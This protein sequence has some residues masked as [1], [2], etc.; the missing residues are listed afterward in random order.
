[1]PATVVRLDEHQEPQQQD[2]TASKKNLKTVLGLGATVFK[3]DTAA[4][5]SPSAKPTPP[6]A[7]RQNTF[8]RKSIDTAR[9][10][11]QRRKQRQERSNVS[12]TCFFEPDAIVIPSSDETTDPIP[13]LENKMKNIDANTSRRPP[14]RMDAQD[15]PWSV[16]VAETPHD[17][18]SYSLYIKSEFFSLGP[19]CSVHF[20]RLEDGYD[21]G[22]L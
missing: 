8:T 12:D 1:M 19:R 2:A 16:S 17:A 10:Y 22:Y 15:G 11:S 5:L 6:T 4:Q 14:V 13:T 20:V 3:D 9:S 21:I 7:R 18:R